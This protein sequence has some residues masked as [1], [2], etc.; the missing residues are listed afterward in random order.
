MAKLTKEEPLKT[1]LKEF[2]YLVM[3]DGVQN[4]VDAMRWILL[5]KGIELEHVFGCSYCQV[6]DGWFDYCPCSVLLQHIM[7]EKG[8]VALMGSILLYTIRK[9]RTTT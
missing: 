9:I 5:E 8:K 7:R 4:A 3:R 2:H 1:S 6:I